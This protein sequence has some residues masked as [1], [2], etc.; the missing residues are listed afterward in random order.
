MSKKQ[1]VKK[2]STKVSFFKKMGFKLS[3]MACG[4]SIVSAVVCMLVIVPS[5]S[6]IVTDLTLNEMKS[7]VT[8][9]EGQVEDAIRNEAIIPYST[10]KEVMGEMQIE[11]V[12]SSYVYLTDAKGI[13]KYHPTESKVNQ[14]VENE[15]VKGIVAKIQKGEEPENAVVEYEYKG[16]MKYAGYAVLSDKSVL[17]LTAD[18]NDILSGI[19]TI[20]Y[21]GIAT[22][23]GVAVVCT[24]LG[25]FVVML[26]IRPLLRLTKVI[27]QTA[28]LDFTNDSE[29]IAV[30]KQG[31][32]VGA[33]GK[34]VAQMREN[35]RAMVVEIKNTSS[36]IT[37]DV[38]LVN[39][40]SNKI[41]EECMDNSAT[42]EQLAAGMQET[43]ATTGTITSNIGGMKDGA[44]D[45]TKLSREGVNL[46]GEVAERALSLQEATNVAAKRTTDM[47][48]NIKVQAEKA[49]EAAECVHQINEMTESIMQISSQTSLL[50]LNASIEAARAGEAGKG[51]AVVASEIGKLANETSESVTSINGIVEQVNASVA[52]MVKSMEDTT[53]FLE[54][55]VLKDYEQFKEVS[56]QYNADADVFKE[57]MEE[58]E[59]SINSLTDSIRIIADAI[60]GINATVDEAAVGVSDIAEKTSNVVIETAQNAELVDTCMESVD[61]LEQIAAK[62]SI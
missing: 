37:D 1:K 10:Y 46:S 24:V 34:A 19:R 13:M 33:M 18:E 43:S 17:V 11:G 58:V 2:D 44:A 61:K 45:I 62:F 38:T 30:A 31:D 36:K 20:T 28:D 29:V 49:M 32:E 23:V 50:A 39:D 57:S 42:T 40:V 60:N 51:F 25:F 41:R 54:E 48:E 12:E 7:L 21:T 22:T 53:N 16:E 6:Q 3:C 5:S 56:E 15:V 9:F 26:L 8:A 52:E 14:P 4:I 47:Y 55:V 27:G 59:T 35:L